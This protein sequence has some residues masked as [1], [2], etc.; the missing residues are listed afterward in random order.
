MLIA[1]ARKNGKA[2]QRVRRHASHR[3]ERANLARELLPLANRVGDH[4]EER[5][6]RAADLPLDR[7]GGDRELEVLRAD[8]LRHVGE[9]VV[10]RAAEAGLGQHALELR[11]RRRMSL[12]DDRLQALLERMARLERSGDRDQQIRQLVLERLR[13]LRIRSQ[14]NAERQRADRRRSP[15]GSRAAVTRRPRS[16]CRTAATSRR[17]STRTP[18]AR[19][20]MSPRSSIFCDRSASD[21]GGRTRARSREADAVNAASRCSRDTR[22]VRRAPAGVRREPSCEPSCRA[23]RRGARGRRRARAA[24]AMSPTTSAPPVRRRTSA[25]A[26]TAREEP[27]RRRAEVGRRVRTTT[28]PHRRRWP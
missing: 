6:E 13:R 21:G 3:G 25:G 28:S 7:D 11:R 10:H 8:A 16:A 18:P 1:T 22:F 9:R 26:S 2:D 15:R 19:N 20:G 5:R 17:R 24:P 4:V 12:V 23:V 14:T 27:L